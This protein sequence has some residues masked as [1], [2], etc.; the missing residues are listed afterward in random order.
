[1]GGETTIISASCWANSGPSPRGRGNLGQHGPHVAAHGSIPAW[2]GKPP[3]TGRWRLHS[4]VHPR[5]GGE[6]SLGTLGQHRVSGPSPRGRGNPFL[7]LVRNRQGRSIPAWA[8][9]PL[10]C[11][12]THAGET[13]HPRVG[14][15]TFQKSRSDARASGPSPRGRGN[16]RSHERLPPLWGPSPRGRGNPSQLNSVSSVQGS[17]PAWAGKPGNRRRRR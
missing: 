12:W 10:P 6:T 3:Q 5:V 17:I 11:A 2:A 7:H 14:G 15:E 13:V 9:K 4:A 8:G 1:M 16:H